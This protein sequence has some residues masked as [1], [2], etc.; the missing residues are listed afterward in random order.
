MIKCGELHV[1]SITLGSSIMRFVQNKFSE[2]DVWSSN[3]GEINVLLRQSIDLCEQW[4][5][6][7]SALTSRF[8]KRLPS[9]PWKGDEV[10]CA[11]LQG[12]ENRIREVTH[13]LT[14]VGSCLS[15]YASLFCFT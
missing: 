13:K 10:K 14:S 15:H 3:F 5:T 11:T 4:R 7:C 8:W 9:H 1:H 12:F 6:A 2:V